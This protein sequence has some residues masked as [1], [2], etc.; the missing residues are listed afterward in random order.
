MA[1]IQPTANA[2][3]TERRTQSKRRPAGAAANLSRRLRRSGDGAFRGVV[4]PLCTA[5][6]G[7]TNRA[8]V[9]VAGRRV[10]A[11]EQRSGDHLRERNELRDAVG[12]LAARQTDGHFIAERMAE[13]G[14]TDR[15]RDRDLV[16]IEIDE[17]SE[18]D[19]VFH[20]LTATHLLE[21]DTGAEAHLIRGDC[22]LGD[23]RELARAL[24]QV[25]E[26]RLDELLALEGGLVL[27][28]LTEVA[29]LHGFPDGERQRDGELVHEAVDLIREL[30]L[31]LFE[32]D[33][34][35]RRVILRRSCPPLHSRR[36]PPPVQLR[37]ALPT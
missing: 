35:M 15:R 13:Q 7:Y 31:H 22:A 34:S 17:V 24:G 27:G 1:K 8:A 25:I 16:R 11:T 10:P 4:L 37:A 29:Q 19:D 26:P 14:A 12:L 20:T 21:H 33:I 36:A 6:A 30:L 32:H 9:P 3:M 23:L 2:E 18:H 5:G 28:I